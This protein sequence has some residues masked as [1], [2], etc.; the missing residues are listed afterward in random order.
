MKRPAIQ[1]SRTRSGERGVTMV[2][3]AVA[4]VAIIA[5]AALSIDVITLYLAREEAQRSADAPRCPRPRSFRSPDSPAIPRTRLAIGARF[6]APTTAP[7]AS[8][9]D[10]EGG[11]RAR[12]SRWNCSYHDQRDLFRWEWWVHRLGHSRLHIALVFR[13]WRESNGDCAN[14]TGQPAQLFLADLGKYWKHNQRNGNCGDL[15]FFQFGQC[16]KSDDRHHHSCSAKVREAVGG[17]KSGSLNTLHV[18]GLL[19]PRR[20]VLPLYRTW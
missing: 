1:K 13:L 15:Q 14:H 12:P 4:M 9:L 7:M 2:I 19:Q 11:S 10:R 18:G 3:V 8:P 6:A 20:P 5:M 16:G 17:S